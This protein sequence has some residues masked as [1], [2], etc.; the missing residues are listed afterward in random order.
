LIDV[1]IISLIVFSG[2]IAILVGVLLLVEAKVV[3][4]GDRTIVIN[5]DHPSFR[6]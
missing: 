2:V 4:K 3:T 6:T 1:Y 5:D